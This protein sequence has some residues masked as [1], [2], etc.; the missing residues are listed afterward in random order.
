MTVLPSSYFDDLE[1]MDDD[2]DSDEELLN[3]TAELER[4]YFER[5]NGRNVEAGKM[6]W[7]IRKINIFSIKWTVVARLSIL[8]SV[9]RHVHLKLHVV[10]HVCSF[11]WI[12]ST[13]ATC[14]YLLEFLIGL[15]QLELLLFILH[16]K[17]FVG[18]MSAFH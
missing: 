5:N 17:C 16:K 10:E 15:V 1:I 11:P 6:L 13:K 12:Y 8:P 18:K 14:A 7:N 2:L 9:S 4:E 3:S